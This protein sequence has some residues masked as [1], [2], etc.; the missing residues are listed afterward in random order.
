ME[1]INCTLK[2]IQIMVSL[3]DQDQVHV[4]HILQ[5]KIGQVRVSFINQPKSGFHKAPLDLCALD[6]E[7]GSSLASKLHAL[8][9]IQKT[10]YFTVQLN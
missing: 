2:Y 8:E 10:T 5:P 3:R 1:L 9:N 6:M 4:V 7:M